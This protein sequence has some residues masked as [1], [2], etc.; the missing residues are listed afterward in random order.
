M[1]NPPPA[2]PH[3]RDAIG[4]LAAMGLGA[5]AGPGPAQAAQATRAAQ[6][7]GA[8][9]VVLLG[10]SSLDNKAYVGT[11]PD[12]VAHLRRRLPSPWQ[13]TLAAVDGAVAADLRRQADRLPADATHLVV[14]VGGNDALR[15]EGVFREPARSVGEGLARLAEAREQFRQDYA[16]MLGTVLAR[17]LPTALCTIYDPRFPDPLRQRL[18]IAGLALFNDVII[19]AAFAR[20]LP[21]LDL[22]LICD[23]DADFANPI[24][25]SGQGGGKIA[26][27]VQ[28]LLLE[29]DFGRRRAAAFTG[30]P[31][32]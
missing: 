4:T 15:R 2:T 30:G 6:A 24:E 26:A 25:P 12:V 21:L 27:A 14:S 10:D 8:G 3:R 7:G 20:G 29:H 11:A 1:Q 17:G 28:Q 16:A 19:R 22:R 32:R 31:A 5:A 23:E 9:H 13:A 18:G